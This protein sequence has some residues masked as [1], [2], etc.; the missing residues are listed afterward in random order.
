MLL[1][2]SAKAWSHA[3]NAGGLWK[4]SSMARLVKLYKTIQARSII[5]NLSVFELKHIAVQA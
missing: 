3:L 1:S 5:R 4:M 2:L